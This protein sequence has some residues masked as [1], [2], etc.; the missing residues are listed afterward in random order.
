MREPE[1]KPTGRRRGEKCVAK[2]RKRNKWQKRGP[3]DQK[4]EKSQEKDKNPY[5]QRARMYLSAYFPQTEFGPLVSGSQILPEI[6]HKLTNPL[7]LTSMYILERNPTKKQQIDCARTSHPQ[8]IEGQRKKRQ[9]QGS[10]FART[11]RVLSSVMVFP[12]VVIVF[13][14]W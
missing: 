14:Y 5:P 4:R 9:L 2:G 3:E 12:F 10:R 1:R 13:R 11:I 6:K 7:P 8:V